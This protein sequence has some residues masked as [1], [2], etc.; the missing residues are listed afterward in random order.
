MSKLQYLFS[1]L[2]IVCLLCAPQFAQE[3][4]ERQKAES[5]SIYGLLLLQDDDAA[6]SE[7]F[8]IVREI[9]PSHA[10]GELKAIKDKILEDKPLKAR[11][12]QVTNSDMADL[13]DNLGKIVKIEGSVEGAQ[14]AEVLR[15]Y[16]SRLEPLAM[17]IGS[18]TQAQKDAAGN[19]SQLELKEVPQGALFK[20]DKTYAVSN[21]QEYP[22]LSDTLDQKICAWGF[23][24]ESESGQGRFQIWDIRNVL[25]IKAR[26]R[27]IPAAKVAQD[28][29]EKRWEAED[30]ATGKKYVVSY[31]EGLGKELASDS[32]EEVFHLQGYLRATDSGDEALVVTYHEEVA[33]ANPE[34]YR[35]AE[36]KQATAPEIKRNEMGEESIYGIILQDAEVDER[37]EFCEVKTCKEEGLKA[38]K[39]AVETEK[40]LEVQPG[41]PSEREKLIETEKPLLAE[42]MKSCRRFQITNG[43]EMEDDLENNLERLVRL[44][45]RIEGDANAEVLQFYVTHVEPLAMVIGTLTNAQKDEA[46][47]ISRLELQ[48]VPKG[49]VLSS[50]KT[51]L[52]AN[53]KEC[54]EIDQWMGQRLVVFGSIIETEGDKSSFKIWDVRPALEFKARLRQVSAEQY[55]KDTKVA[56]DPN[57]KVWEVEDLASGKRYI[58]SNDEGLGTDLDSDSEKEIYHIQGYVRKGE[59]GKECFHV[60]YHEHVE[61]QD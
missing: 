6:T 52:V 46:G 17:V 54:P 10:E 61:T 15:L 4:P 20:S 33:D 29:A 43:E 26:L 16:V 14:D 48:E 53:V 40:E 8:Y 45:G 31:E 32:A 50:E 56:R 1:C 36:E 39:T 27:A 21:L 23:I 24:T 30:L 25:E 57:I 41:M 5:H 58:V 49:A 51:Y 55:K 18:L 44:Q 7:D 3:N 37:F 13:D 38:E 35:K 22:G 47:A 2:F 9:R 11:L 60:T 34:A 28:A 12:F 19:L 59:G 42:G